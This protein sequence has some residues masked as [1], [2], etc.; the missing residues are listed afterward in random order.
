M[1][2]LSSQEATCWLLCLGA[3][4]GRVPPQVESQEHL[5]SIAPSCSLLDFHRGPYGTGRTSPTTRNARPVEA[6]PRA[7][8]GTQARLRRQA[9]QLLQQD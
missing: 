4:T 6:L 2:P 7:I 3:L 9:A 8:E 5:C 1:A